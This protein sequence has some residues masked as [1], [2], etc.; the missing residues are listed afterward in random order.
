MLPDDAVRTITIY[1]RHT[2]GVTGLVTTVRRVLKRCSFEE[3]SITTALATGQ[4][5]RIP[6]VIRIFTDDNPD[7]QYIEPHEWAKKGILDLDGFWTINL[8][9]R[10]FIVPWEETRTFSI[11]TSGAV[12][13]AENTFARDNPGCVRATEKNDNRKA[14]GSHIRLGAISAP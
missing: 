9:E 2:D 12:T 6:S 3:R 8:V 11:G 1:P 13:A 5:L 7:L 10:T 14:H 4:V